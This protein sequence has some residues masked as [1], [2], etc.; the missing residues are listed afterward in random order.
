MLED[1]ETTTFGMHFPGMDHVFWH[2]IL[3]QMISSR[4]FVPLAYPLHPQ[5]KIILCNT[6]MIQSQ[7]LFSSQPLMSSSH[8]PSC[9]HSPSHGSS[10]VP[11]LPQFLHLRK[12]CGISIS[13]AFFRGKLYDCSANCG[14][15]RLCEKSNCA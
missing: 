14:K 3:F 8:A 11:W 12:S 9:C 10:L 7:Q 5:Q 2:A 4:P 1:A 15:N 13:K 6:C